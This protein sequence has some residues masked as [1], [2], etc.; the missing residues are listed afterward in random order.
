MYLDEG[1]IT[2]MEYGLP[3]TA[4]WGLGID[5]LTMLLTDTNNIKEVATKPLTKGIQKNMHIQIEIE[6]EIEAETVARQPKRKASL[7][8]QNEK[9]HWTN[10]IL[11]VL[12]EMSCI[13]MYACGA[14]AA[15]AGF[16][17]PC[18]EARRPRQV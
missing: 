10:R 4:G 8:S 3:P 7:D 18:N 5:R 17:L 13:K 12:L 14:D 16:I 6:I 1:F 15:F 2:A 11:L 9:L